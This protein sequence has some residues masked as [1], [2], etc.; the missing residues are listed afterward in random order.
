MKT[1]LFLLTKLL[2]ISFSLSSCDAALVAMNQMQQGM[3]GQCIETNTQSYLYNN[4]TQNYDLEGY[5]V[6]DNDEGENIEEIEMNWV[7]S[8]RY[9]HSNKGQFGEFFETS[10]YSN[11]TYKILVYCSQWHQP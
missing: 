11:S 2:L 9:E 10:P 8:K 4:E 3:G 7:N 6:L 5:I 1:K